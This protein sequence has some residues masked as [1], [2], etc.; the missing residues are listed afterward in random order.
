MTNS[1]HTEAPPATRARPRPPSRQ[2]LWRA[3]RPGGAGAHA[4]PTATW[5]QVYDLLVV[6]SGHTLPGLHF[7]TDKRVT[8]PVPTSGAAVRT[9]GVNIC[10]ARRAESPGKSRCHQS[11]IQHPQSW[12]FNT[13][14]ASEDPKGRISGKT[15]TGESR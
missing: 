9:E 14:R 2:P 12:D 11:I 5:A 7:L 8:T 13:E 10:S 15:R 1:P 3:V 6:N 4:G